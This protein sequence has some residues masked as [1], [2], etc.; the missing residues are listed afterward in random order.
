MRATPQGAVVVVRRAQ[1]PAFKGAGQVPEPATIVVIG[2][3]SREAYAKAPIPVAINT[4]YRQRHSE[5][6]A[7]K[8]A[9]QL[10]VAW[11]PDLGHT[12]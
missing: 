11:L 8:T 7:V 2:A 12:R 4:P 10:A 1:S 9:R 3:R 5:T 6:W